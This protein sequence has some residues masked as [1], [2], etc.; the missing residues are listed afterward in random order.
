MN[1]GLTLQGVTI[2][3]EGINGGRFEIES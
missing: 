2:Y 1:N 3:T